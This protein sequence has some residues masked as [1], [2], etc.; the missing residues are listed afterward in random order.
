MK[1]HATILVVEDDAP[2]REAYKTI[3][4][5]AGGYI[6]WQ[7]EDGQQALSILRDNGTDPNVILLDLRM[8]VLDGIGFCGNINPQSIRT[9]QWL[10]LA[11]MMHIRTLMRHIALVWIAMC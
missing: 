6:V 2:L 8:P 3:L 10:Y 1:K 9:V 7:A 5:T 4:E 11:I